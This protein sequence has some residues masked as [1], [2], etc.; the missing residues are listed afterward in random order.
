LKWS[1]LAELNGRSSWLQSMRYAF[2]IVQLPALY[3]Q[4]KHS[5]ELGL[6]RINRYEWVIINVFHTSWVVVHVK[7]Y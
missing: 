1:C 4:I 3:V 7:Y 6:C 5:S 2:G